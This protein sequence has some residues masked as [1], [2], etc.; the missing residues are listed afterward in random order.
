MV[1]KFFEDFKDG[2]SRWTEVNNRYIETWPGNYLCNN[3]YFNSN[4]NKK[5][6]DTVYGDNSRIRARFDLDR[7][8]DCLFKFQY[9]G[10]N[11]DLNNK[12]E[13]SF[14]FSVMNSDFNNKI[15]EDEFINVKNDILETYSNFLIGSGKS[16]VNYIEFEGISPPNYGYGVVITN[17]A[18]FC[19]DN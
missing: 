17:I 15:Y 6:F 3:N 14:K 10:N 11:A 16:G 9:C 7:N 5:A 12:I 18:V 1:N 2:V 8:C 4:P 13:K 19:C